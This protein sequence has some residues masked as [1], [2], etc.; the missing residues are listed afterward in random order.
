[1]FA[2]PRVGCIAQ[3][4]P[5]LEYIV[6]SII[7]PYPQ[8]IAFWRDDS[9]FKTCDFFPYHSFSDGGGSVLSVFLPALSKLAP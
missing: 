6:P 8:R 4:R 5:A 1:M 2:V 7:S 9:S 3:Q